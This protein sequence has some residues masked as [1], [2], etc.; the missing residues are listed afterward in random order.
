MSAKKSN[1]PK[2]APRDLQAQG[3]GVGL[4]MPQPPQHPDLQRIE[5]ARP[6]PPSSPQPEDRLSPLPMP[7]NPPAA[8]DVHKRAREF[9]QR[10]EESKASEEVKL[11]STQ[12]ESIHAKVD[13]CLREL[14]DVKEMVNR[15]EEKQKADFEELMRVLSR[16]K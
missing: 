2:V 16:S 4:G 7:Q 11:A 12:E 3:A 5:K 13:R 1:A 15:I 6:S 8:G 14:A 10:Q 9:L